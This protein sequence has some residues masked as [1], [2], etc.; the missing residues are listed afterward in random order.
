MNI[1][2]FSGYS[3]EP[4][5]L[6]RSVSSRH[7]SQS[8]N[9]GTVSVF[10]P[11]SPTS[12]SCPGDF[13]SNLHLLGK[14]HIELAGAKEAK[15]NSGK[16]SAKWLKHVFRAAAILS[17]QSQGIKALGVALG[18]EHQSE[19]VDRSLLNGG[20]VAGVS[21]LRHWRLSRIIVVVVLG[22][23]LQLGG[24]W[25]SHFGLGF[26]LCFYIG[27]R[28]MVFLGKKDVSPLCF[29]GRVSQ[30]WWAQEARVP[31]IAGSVNK[32]NMGTASLGG[33]PSN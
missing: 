17:Y 27:A 15:L 32:K 12:V 25:G 9:L 30:A 13:V 8:T 6:S 19:L 1:S 18:L 22:V 5:T 4:M 24:Y 31:G 33:N 29:F 16:M 20:Q 26:C 21:I 3:Q 11:Q 10:P 7:F 28:E 23:E 14:V 2:S